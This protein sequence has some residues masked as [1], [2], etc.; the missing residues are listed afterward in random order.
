MMANELKE[1]VVLQCQTIKIAIE[2]EEWLNK[3]SEEM[4]LPK[5]EVQRIVKDLMR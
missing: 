4:N 3:T 1:M 5:D 2:F